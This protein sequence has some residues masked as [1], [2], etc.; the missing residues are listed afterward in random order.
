MPATGHSLPGRRAPP[1]ADRS[2]VTA[3]FV[4]TELERLPKSGGHL[5]R[6][7]VLPGL[8]H[9]EIAAADV[10]TL[11]KLLLREVGQISVAIDV[12][13]KFDTGGFTHLLTMQ[14]TTGT[15]SEAYFAL[16]LTTEVSRSN[17]G[18]KN[19]AKTNPTNPGSA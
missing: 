9:L 6:W 2:N 5:Y 12:L 15:E 10:G 11:G 7:N 14:R 17:K 4:P 18:Y 1:D 16:R 3:Q 8:D 19:A 13:A